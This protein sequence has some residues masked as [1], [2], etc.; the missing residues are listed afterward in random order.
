MMIHGRIRFHFFDR[1][2]SWFW[3]IQGKILGLLCNLQVFRYRT[4]NYPWLGG[5]TVDLRMPFWGI[6]LFI[7]C[8]ISRASCPRRRYWGHRFLR[9]Y[10]CQQIP[11]VFLQIYQLFLIISHGQQ[12][13]ILRDLLLWLAGWILLFHDFC[14]ILAVLWE[15]SCRWHRYWRQRRLHLCYLPSIIFLRIW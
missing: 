10:D 7:S 15:D 1:D 9:W 4:R 12:L 3:N 11:L 14:G 6:F 2:L 8:R 13:Q 5:N